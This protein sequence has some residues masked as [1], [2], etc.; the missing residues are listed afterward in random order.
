MT[1][2]LFELNQRQRPNVLVLTVE[3]TRFDAISKHNTPFIWRM[4][5]SGHRF[6]QH[7][8]SSAW[9][10]SN[11]VSILTGLSTF[12]HGVHSRDASIPEPWRPP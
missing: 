12:R 7:R 8:T 10:G 9:T 6:M 4:A 11:I 5:A 1:V 3:S 2:A